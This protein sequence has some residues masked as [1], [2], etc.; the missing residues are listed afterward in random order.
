MELKIDHR[1]RTVHEALGIS[2]ERRTELLATLE[3]KMMDATASGDMNLSQTI[4]FILT[5]FENPLEQAWLIYILGVGEGISRERKKK[6]VPIWGLG[7]A[8]GR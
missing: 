7:G 2:S 6:I 4:E 8:S 1:E 3:K 5:R